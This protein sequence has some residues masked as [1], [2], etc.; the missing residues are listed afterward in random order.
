M[1]IVPYLDGDFANTVAAEVRIACEIQYPVKKRYMS[2][3]PGGSNL[4]Q[5]QLLRM[6]ASLASDQS[7]IA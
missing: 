6:P 3:S 1:P 4:S 5:G 2:C 7:P